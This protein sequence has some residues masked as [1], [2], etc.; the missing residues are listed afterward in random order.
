MQLVVLFGVIDR[1]AR[2]FDDQIFLGHKGLTAQTA[3]GLQAPGAV[4]QVFFVFIELIERG[5]TLSHDD[6]ASGAS[7]A[8][9]AGVLDV[10]AVIQQSFANAVA[11]IGFDLSALRTNFDMGEDSD[12]GHGAT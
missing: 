11:H 2:D 5:K 6:V 1:I 8:H 7:T 12:D 4:K 9:V 10:D 3:V